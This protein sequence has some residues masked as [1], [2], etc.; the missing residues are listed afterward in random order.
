VVR[1]HLGPAADRLVR[2]LRNPVRVATNRVPHAPRVDRQAMLIVVAVIRAEEQVEALM[3]EVYHRLQ[4][5]TVSIPATRRLRLRLPNLQV[6][7][8]LT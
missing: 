4:G 3:L 5:F 2:R 7:E 1:R 6:L 8:A